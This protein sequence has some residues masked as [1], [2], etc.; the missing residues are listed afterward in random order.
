LDVFSGRLSCFPAGFLTGFLD[1]S[2]AAEPGFLGLNHP[3]ARPFSPFLRLVGGIHVSTLVVQTSIFRYVLYHVVFAAHVS[4]V[5]PSANASSKT[6]R[7]DSQQQEVYLALWRTYDRL[8]ALEDELL[9]QYDLTAQQY[10][11][12]RLLQAAHPMPV[13][14]LQLSARLISRAPDITRMLDRLQERTWIERIRSIEDRRA[15]LVAITSPG[16]A[17]VEELAEPIHQMH[18][19]QVGHLT[20]VEMKSLCE[21]LAQVR[22][23]HEPTNSIWVKPNCE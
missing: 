7:F 15:V 4:P 21:L 16:M 13:P 10:N 18:L 23:P 17:L 22:S 3:F 11:V 6:K 1:A 9:S 2:L 12:L 5:M 14:T 20:S 19:S 8:R